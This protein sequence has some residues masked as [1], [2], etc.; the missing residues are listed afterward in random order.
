MPDGSLTQGARGL[1]AGWAG[2]L[3]VLV[4]NEV[5]IA[6]AAPGLLEH[7]PSISDLGVNYVLDT[8]T[9]KVEFFFCGYPVPNYLRTYLK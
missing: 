2:Q 8:C 1:V 9:N 7:V 4:P 3:G 6:V 5:V